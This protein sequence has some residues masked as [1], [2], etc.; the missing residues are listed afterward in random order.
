MG[1]NCAKGSAS[2]MFLIPASELR[3]VNFKGK[4]TATMKSNQSKPQRKEI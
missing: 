4:S 1:K 3:M 2:E